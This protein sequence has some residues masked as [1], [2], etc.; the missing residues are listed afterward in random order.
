VII[1][2]IEAERIILREFEEADW[3]S[4]HCYLSDPEAVS[5]TTYGVHSEQDSR[6]YIRFAIRLRQAEPRVY[7][8]FAVVRK[9]DN[10]LI[11]SCG[12]YVRTGA[13][14]R[15]EIG[16]IYAKEFWGQGYATEAAKV[17]RDFAFERLGMKRVGASCFT[18]NIASARVLEKTG[19]HRVGESESV[20][21]R[22]GRW[23]GISDMF[24]Y[25]LAREEW[26]AIKDRSGGDG[27]EQV[28]ED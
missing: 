2:P 6:D 21:W 23:T 19:M 15:A 17:A 26:A 8:D 25:A 28:S 7:Y 27:N 11:G 3:R 1:S 24:Y 10:Q 14:R 13:E 5:T 4:V 18:S 16:Y 20:P 12:I 22:N 9:S